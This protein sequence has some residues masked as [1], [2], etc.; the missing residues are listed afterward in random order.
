MDG[1]VKLWRRSLLAEAGYRVEGALLPVGA[2][3]LEVADVDLGPEPVD[4]LLGEEVVHQGSLDATVVVNQLLE[5]M[6]RAVWLVL[7]KIGR[8]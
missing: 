3:P 2:L 6:S 5:Q 1:E 4:H 8:V 7:E